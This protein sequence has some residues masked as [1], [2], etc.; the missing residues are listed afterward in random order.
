MPLFTLITPSLQR[1]SLLACCDSID[2]Q[3]FRDWEHIVQLDCAG[4]DI[5][6]ALVGRIVHPQRTIR[7]CGSRHANYGN[8]CRNHAWAAATGEWCAH[9]DDDNK[10][11]DDQVLFD[12]AGVLSMTQEMWTL[13]PISR[14][15]FYFLNDPPG[16]CQTDTANVIARRGVA[17]WPDVPNYEADGIWVEQLKAK[18][19]YRV[20]PDFR[21]IVIMER[22]NHGK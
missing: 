1:E 20:F 2:K 12:L 9:I 8:T 7:Y 6:S 4:E 10:L 11:A 14:H 16:L 17:R 15:G 19:P 3:S 18:Y 22:S 21:P 13:F 5:D